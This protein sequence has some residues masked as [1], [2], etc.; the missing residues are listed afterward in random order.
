MKLFRLTAA[1]ILLL[2]S[3]M[4]L[5]HG[6]T[7]KKADHSIEINASADKVWAQLK[8][9]DG[10][11]D[12]HP[13][14]IESSGDGSHTAGTSQRILTLKKGQ[15]IEELTE[16]L[17]ADQEYS[18]R[19]A[20]EDTDTFPVSSYRATLKVQSLSA[21]KSSVRWKGRFYRGDTGN[22][23]PEQLNDEAAIQAMDEFFTKGLQGLKNKIELGEQ[24]SEASNEDKVVVKAMDDASS[25]IDTGKQDCSSCE[26]YYG[27][28]YLDGTVES[29]K[30]R[31]SHYE[32]DY[33]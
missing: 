6:P 25:E 9:F 11:A 24:H 17:D 29:G 4:L 13:L 3:T 2:F 7:P 30:Q 27:G 28:D 5:A 12:W 15:L 23:P 31:A 14:V 19:L 21:D 20:K 26:S 22:T 1:W 32:G 33:L 18:Y 10:M 16:Y 8:A